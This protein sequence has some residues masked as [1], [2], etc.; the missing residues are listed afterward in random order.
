MIL[1]F[2]MI[3]FIKSVSMSVYVEDIEASDT[4]KKAEVEE[5]VNIQLP[6]YVK[7][8]NLTKYTKYNN[9]S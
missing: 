6:E 9:I 7:A 4:E 2:A 8:I 3:G 5:F 1:I